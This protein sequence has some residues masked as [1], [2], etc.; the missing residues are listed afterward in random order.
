MA[1]WSDLPRELL[2]L[3]AKR[4]D[5]H[6]DLLRFRSV[7]SSWRCSV[8][9]RAPSLPSRFPIIQNDGTTETSGGFYLSKRTICRLGLPEPRRRVPSDD[10]LIKVEEN[11]PQSICLLNPL[12]S[13]KSKCLSSTFPRTLDLSNIRISELGREY[14]LQYVNSRPFADA[15]GDVNNLYMEKVVFASNPDGTFAVLTI[16]I[17]G[18]LAVFKSGDENWSV[19][20]DFPSPYDDVALFDGRF[21]AVDGN[22]R[23]VVVEMEPSPSVNLIAGAMFGG[24]KKCLVESNG[25]LLLVDVYLRMGLAEED[26]DVDEGDGSSEEL[27]R[28]LSERMGRFKVYR[29][30]RSEQKWVEVRSLGDR[31]L[32]L[33]DNC[34]FSASAS[35]FY[36][37]K[38]NCIYFTDLGDIEVFDLD[39]GR[40][41][42]DSRGCSELFWPPPAWITA[43]SLDVGLD[44]VM[45]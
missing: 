22:G 7:C 2:V 24:D 28:I 17:S 14:V 1:E 19:I 3:I 10:W 38:G 29:L 42:D 16:H 18:K 23:A 5:N 31:I 39:E 43:M 9:P 32:F 27:P 13:L 12:S 36:G 45:I 6:F 41:I 37:R 8:S 34:A 25:E 33:G 4:L 20:E 40:R 11:V 21:Y 30:S 35:D 26:S 15:L 44:Q